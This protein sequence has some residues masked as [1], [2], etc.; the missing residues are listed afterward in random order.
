MMIQ[1]FGREIDP[2]FSVFADGTADRAAV[3]SRSDS[4]EDSREADWTLMGYTRFISL[5]GASG[6]MLNTQLRHSVPHSPDHRAVQQRLPGAGAVRHEAVCDP[7][8]KG[9]EKKIHEG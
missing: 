3:F 7:E 5:D 1:T 6:I 9:E 4:L 2:F 8:A